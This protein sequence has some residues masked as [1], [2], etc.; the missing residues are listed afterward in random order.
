MLTSQNVPRFVPRSLSTFGLHSL[1]R[2]E[3]LGK[4]HAKRSHFRSSL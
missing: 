2:L 1:V 3:T 4:Y